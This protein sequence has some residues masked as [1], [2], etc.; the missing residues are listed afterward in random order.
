MTIDA[1]APRI[2]P[3]MRRVRD[4]PCRIEEIFTD[5][6]F[7]GTR[8][9]SHSTREALRRTNTV[10]TIGIQSCLPTAPMLPRATNENFGTFSFL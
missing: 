1:T 8:A 10:E 4:S 7:H 2:I 3:C 6:A 9:G 5:V